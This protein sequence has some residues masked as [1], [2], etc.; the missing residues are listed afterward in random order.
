MSKKPSTRFPFVN[1]K[2]ALERAEAI[3]INDKAGRGLS[4]P[5]AFSAWGYSSK[6]SGGF[7]TVGA[8]KG[9]GLIED[10]GAND[11]RI[12]KLTESARRYFLTEIPED[13][14]LLKREFAAKPSLFAH[15]MEQWGGEFPD[16]PVARTH[17]KT[18]V[19]LNEQSAR[20]ALGIYKDNL[21]FAPPKGVS[22]A[23]TLEPVENDEEVLS[24]RLHGMEFT[25]PDR[26][27]SGIAGS[28]LHN[29]SQLSRV[30]VDDR[31]IEAMDRDIF[32]VPEGEVVLIS[33]KG[34]SEDSWQ[35]ISDWL[36]LMKRKLGRKVVGEA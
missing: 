8:L 34:L 12:V 27:N 3:Y 7:Q 10:E 4:L 24:E 26:Q 35:D 14:E 31:Q 16:D 25:G 5:V 33:P 15:L 19:E 11:D 13:K 23:A 22:A 30:S 29:Q 2:K 36:E 18:F 32:S 17:L 6:S 28:A 1:L 20:S 9:Y 21:S